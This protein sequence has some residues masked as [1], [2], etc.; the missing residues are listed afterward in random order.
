MK[1]LCKKQQDAKAD[2]AEG[3]EVNKTELLLKLHR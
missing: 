2:R 3:N 1:E